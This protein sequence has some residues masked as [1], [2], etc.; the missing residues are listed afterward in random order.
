L[1]GP[2]K[3]ALPNPSTAW[4]LLRV[5]ISRNDPRPTDVTYPPS[6]TDICAVCGE[7]VVEGPDRVSV[8]LVPVFDIAAIVM[9]QPGMLLVLG[10]CGFQNFETLR[11]QYENRSR[12][13]WQKV[14][15]PDQVRDR[16]R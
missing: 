1:E 8:V 5:G 15:G 7:A 13:R 16:Y 14:T 3:V 12:S 6:R 4:R 10:I 9:N 11:D 2:S